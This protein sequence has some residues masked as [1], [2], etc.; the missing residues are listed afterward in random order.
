MDRVLVRSQ[1]ASMSYGYGLF[2]AAGP[3]LVRWLHLVK[4]LSELLLPRGWERHDLENVPRLINRSRRLALVVVRG[5]EA[6]GLPFSHVGRFPR[7]KYPRGAATLRAVVNNTTPV[8]PLFDQEEDGMVNLNEYK[9]W[10]LV[11]HVDS[12]AIR[13]EI[14]LP[15]ISESVYLERWTERLLL[16]SARTDGLSA[17]ELTDDEVLDTEDFED[18]DIAVDPL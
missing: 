12:E 11:V 8:F 17:L 7:S 6:T 2:P 10:F 15:L 1:A 5:D 14:S 18:I 9:T 3:G 13:A 16:P 4:N